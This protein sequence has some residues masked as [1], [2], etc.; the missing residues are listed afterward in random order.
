[1][2]FLFLAVDL[3]KWRSDDRLQVL[4]I[5]TSI[6]SSFSQTI[7]DANLSYSTLVR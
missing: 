7:G 4:I 3:L 1:M 2:P 5:F 6:K